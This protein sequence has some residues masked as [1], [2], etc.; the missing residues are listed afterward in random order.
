MAED[1]PTTLNENNYNFINFW[2][3]KQAIQNLF[4]CYVDITF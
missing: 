2:G 4:F 3:Q 1:T